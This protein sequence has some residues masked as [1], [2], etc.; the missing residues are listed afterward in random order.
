MGDD[1]YEYW[2]NEDEVKIIHVL[3]DLNQPYT[4]TQWG[5][6]GHE[7]VDGVGYIPNNVP[8]IIYGG[9]S[10]DASTIRHWFPK[11]SETLFPITIFINQ[12]MQVVHI[13]NSSLG[14]NDTNYII[15]CMLNS[16]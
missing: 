4:C 5:N 13:E 14:L 2:E 9:I 8:S 15:E 16:L 6:I 7:N 10:S 1:I 11:D 12:H 3:Y